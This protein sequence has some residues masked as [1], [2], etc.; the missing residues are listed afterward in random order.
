[1]EREYYILVSTNCKYFGN[2]SSLSIIILDSFLKN[3]I[4]SRTIINR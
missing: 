4:N 3:I 1:M 2:H